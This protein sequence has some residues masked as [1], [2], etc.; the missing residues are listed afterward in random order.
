MDESTH[1]TQIQEV[2]TVNEPESCAKD[3]EI[4]EPRSTAEL[5]LEIG[6]AM[7]LVGAAVGMYCQQIKDMG[8]S[9]PAAENM[10]CVYHASLVALAFK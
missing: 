10:A 6:D 4:A 5:L 1:D 8:F 7:E 9:V 2:D 3:T